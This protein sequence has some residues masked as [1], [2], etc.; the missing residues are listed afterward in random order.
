MDLIGVLFSDLSGIT[1]DSLTCWLFGF[2]WMKKKHWARGTQC[3]CYF[4]TRWGGGYL[5]L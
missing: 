2:F 5:L 1:V 3:L 4:F